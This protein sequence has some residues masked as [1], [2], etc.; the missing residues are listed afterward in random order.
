MAF[1]DARFPTT[2][3][4]GSSG[5]PSFSTNIVELDGGGDER[6]ARWTSPLYVFDAAQGIRSPAE[7]SA[8]LRH[9]VARRGPAVSFPYKDWGDYASTSDG[10]FPPMGASAVTNVDQV[11]GTGDM[12]RV[13][14]EVY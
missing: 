14:S 5:G 12:D 9:Y 10:M 2:Q 7:A 8:V 11:I 1:H 3:D 4:Y 13:I 6:N